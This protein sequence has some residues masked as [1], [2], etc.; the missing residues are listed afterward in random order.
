MG[1]SGEPVKNA[2]LALGDTEGPQTFPGLASDRQQWVRNGVI[3]KFEARPL[4]SGPLMEGMFADVRFSVTDSATG[5]PLAGVAPGAWLDPMVADDKGTSRDAQ[6]KSRVGLY[7]KSTIG[8]RPLLDLNSYFLMVLNKDASATVIDPTVSVGGITSTLTRI[9]LRQPGMDWTSTNDDKRVFVSM[10]SAGEV[11]VIDGEKFQVLDNIPAGSQPL[12]VALQPDE[13]YLWVGNNAPNEGESGVTVI[14]AQSLKRLK[15]LPTGPGHH[16]IAFSKNSRFA[17]VSSRDAGTVEVFDVATLAS[18]RTLKTG[19]H[20]LSLAYSPLSDAVYVA[21]GR[22]GTITVIDA[23]SLDVRKVIAAQQGLGPMSFTEDGR[24]GFVLNTLN[25]HALVIDSASDSV[26]HDLEVSPE[27]FQVTVTQ[28]Y[29]YIRGLASS[30]VTMVNLSSLGRDRKPILQ[31][32]EAGPAAPRLAGDL[33]LAAGLSPARDN[34]AVFVVNPVDNTTYFYAEGM[35]A[36]MSGYPNR[37]NAAR[38]VRVID[39]SLR[40]VEPGVYSSRVRLPSAG[41]FD[42]AFM[43]NQPQVIHCFT[44]QIEVN[45]A[46][47]K[48]LAIPRVTFLLERRFEPVGKLVPIRIRLVQGRNNTPMTG[49]RDVYL[50]Y[51]LAPSSRPKEVLAVEVGEGIYEAQADLSE[52]GAYYLHARS[53]SLGIRAN[54]QSYASLRVMPVD[55][56]PVHLSNQSPAVSDRTTP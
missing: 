51:F 30:R 43:L 38:A 9:A 48:R 50:R 26:L 5:Q 2:N 54:E 7:L 17:F 39:R 42:V 45:P 6:C 15:F 41:N 44:A 27:P 16:E 29:A 47:E 25:S 34:D 18:A 3:V 35:N 8:A 24:Y 49:A 36:P 55:N 23:H 40:E 10:P 1:H 22:D 14:D 53:E 33:P 12:R 46:L 52:T 11:A 20:P 37:G 19:S 21:D 32:F 13:R 28:N 31:S 4:N 56:S